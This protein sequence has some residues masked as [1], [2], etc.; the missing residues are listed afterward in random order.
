[1]LANSIK[2]FSYRNLVFSKVLLKKV[3]LEEL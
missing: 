2:K 1:M 3:N